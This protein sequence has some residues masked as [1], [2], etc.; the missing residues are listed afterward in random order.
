MPSSSLPDDEPG[1]P[2]PRRNQFIGCAPPYCQANQ[3]V[4]KPW[5]KLVQV[6]RALAGLETLHVGGVAV[7]E[8][9]E[10]RDDVAADVVLVLLHLVLDLDALGAGRSSARACL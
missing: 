10:V 3:M 5:P 8:V 1:D 4:R 7:D 9:A 2:P 6:Q